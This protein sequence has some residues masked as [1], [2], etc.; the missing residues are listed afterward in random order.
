MV[1]VLY[2]RND[3]KNHAGNMFLTQGFITTNYGKN[4]ELHIR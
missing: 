2:N 4:Y 3:I 1:L